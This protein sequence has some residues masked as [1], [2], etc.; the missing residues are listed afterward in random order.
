MSVRPNPG[1]DLDA[2]SRTMLALLQRDQRRVVYRDHAAGVEHVV[3]APSAASPTGLLPAFIVA[4]EALWRE[5]TGQG[6]N[7]DMLHDP[8]A[9]LGYRLR[10]IGAG[11][12]STVMLATMEAAA[13]VAQPGAIIVNDLNAVW[14]A[15]GNRIAANIQGLSADN[16]PASNQGPAP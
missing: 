6:F 3:A 12:F 10:G 4:G 15:A 8:D 5:A 1:V 11:T 16:L 2:V 14:S 9:L 7:L 13:R